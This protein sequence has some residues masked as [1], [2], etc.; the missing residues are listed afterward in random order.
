MFTLLKDLSSVSIF[1]VILRP[2]LDNGRPLLIPLRS[3]LDHAAIVSAREYS[4]NY[5]YSGMVWCKLSIHIIHEI[6]IQAAFIA[7]KHIDFSIF[8]GEYI[9]LKRRIIGRYC[10]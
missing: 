4:G 7:D 1:L 6:F 2:I 10:L 8:H 9:H 5:R 3:I